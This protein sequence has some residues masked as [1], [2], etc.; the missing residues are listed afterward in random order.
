MGCLGSDLHGFLL[1]WCASDRP[2]AQRVFPFTTETSTLSASYS[3]PPRIVKHTFQ[4]AYG[5][6][7]PS[8]CI[9]TERCCH[10]LTSSLRIAANFRYLQL[11]PPLGSQVAFARCLLFIDNYRCHSMT[12]LIDRYRYHAIFFY[13][14]L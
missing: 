8:T 2:C 10:H 3:S 6:F 13:I 9:V 14:F 11:L 5:F 4:N 1:R 7:T 12:F